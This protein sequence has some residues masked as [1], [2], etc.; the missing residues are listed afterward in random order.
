M[1]RWT[2]KLRYFTAA[3]CDAHECPVSRNLYAR[4]QEAFGDFCTVP[5]LAA[6][7][8]EGAPLDLVARSLALSL[9]VTIYVKEYSDCYRLYVDVQW[10]QEQALQ[11][12]WSCFG[13]D[14]SAVENAASAVL[15]TLAGMLC[16]GGKVGCALKVWT[17]V[18]TAEKS[19]CLALAGGIPSGNGIVGRTI[20]DTLSALEHVTKKGLS[21]L[22]CVLVDVMR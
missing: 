13:G 15:A 7:R 8:T 3:A 12:V 14:V 21:Y 20:D 9:T 5:V 17:A 1:E 10:Q 16:D 19:A 22:D 4:V 2:R 18:S 6:G 11:P